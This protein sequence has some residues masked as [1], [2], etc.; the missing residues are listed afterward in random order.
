MAIPTI[1]SRASN[2]SPDK[3]N[4]IRVL[5]ESLTSWFKPIMIFVE[6]VGVNMG[7][8]GPAIDY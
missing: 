5:T 4:C 2:I 8:Q 7:I 6:Y 1:E 3:E